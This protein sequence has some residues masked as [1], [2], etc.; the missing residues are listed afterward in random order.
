MT[1]VF[2]SLSS[3]L[4]NYGHNWPLQSSLVIFLTAY[5]MRQKLHMGYKRPFQIDAAVQLN[6]HETVLRN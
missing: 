1:V 6:S 5:V 4:Y 3:S 2:V